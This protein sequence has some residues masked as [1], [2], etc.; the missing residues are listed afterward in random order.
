[1]AL[2]L[3]FGRFLG[4]AFPLFLPPSLIEQRRGVR[5][6]DSRFSVPRRDPHYVDS[7]A[8][9]VGGVLLALA[10]LG[11]AG[12]TLAICSGSLATHGQDNP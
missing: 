10:P 4:R 11:I 12:S 8:Y 5:V 6:D 2:R 7:I 9:H 3:A 1:M